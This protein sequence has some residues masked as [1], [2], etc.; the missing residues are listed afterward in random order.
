MAGWNNEHEHDWE[1]EGGDADR[2]NLNRSEQDR[3]AQDRWS[4]REARS[5]ERDRPV[6]GERDSGN[7]YNRPLYGHGSG[8]SGA[9]RDRPAWQDR[10]YQGV[11][12]GFRQQEADYESGYRANPGFRSSAYTREDMLG[13]GGRYYGDDGRQRMYREEYAYGADP[14][15]PD[16]RRHG[17][18]SQG[19]GDERYAQQ[20]EQRGGFGGG[21]RS[22]WSGGTGGY[23]DE[24]GYGDVGRGDDR[25]EDRSRE[26]GAFFR[27]T[28]ER[29]KSWF[30]DLGREGGDYGRGARGLGP[31]GDKRP[32]EQ[33]SDEAHQRLTDDPWVDASNISVSVS[34]GEVTLSG[35]VENREAK[36]RAERIVEDL[37]G[38]NH[39]QNNLRV[40]T[41]NP[42]TRAGSGFG[43]SAQAAQM[44]SDD[45]T[46]SETLGATATGTAGRQPGT[47]V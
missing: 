7:G 8:R 42:L 43:D 11:S 31:K 14:V 16:T 32:D 17:S 29:M 13:G 5:F 36:H 26:A 28:G 47:T 19:G 33:I 44:R 30:N 40:K 24:R 39:V 9:D 20:A 2:S 1:K 3:Y 34:G 35:T 38:V 23:G 41:G 4:N 37:S 15:H 25:W 12:P 45:T 21:V 22:T 46:S 18:P 27:R 10:D 6:F